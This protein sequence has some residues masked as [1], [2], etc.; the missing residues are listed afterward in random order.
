MQRGHHDLTRGRVLGGYA[1]GERLASAP[2]MPAA[3]PSGATASLGCPRRRKR[4]SLL[5]HLF[6]RVLRRRFD[7]MRRLFTLTVTQF[8]LLLRYAT[9]LVKEFRQ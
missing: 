4:K 6:V 7:S 9:A 5:V 8:K 3:A 1:G 2:A